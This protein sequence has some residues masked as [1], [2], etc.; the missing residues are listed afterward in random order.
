ML[1]GSSAS[2]ETKS[3]GYSVPS[4]RMADSRTPGRPSLGPRREDA[5]IPLREAD[6]VDREH[7]PDLRRCH[8][9]VRRAQLVHLAG[10]PVA[11]QRQ[12]RV[13]ARGQHQAQP[14][15]PGPY[16]AVQA[17]QDFGVSE[18]VRVID[19]HDELG[20]RLGHR[21]EQR[22]D[23]VDAG[24]PRHRDRRAALRAVAFPERGHEQAPEPPRLGVR[25]RRV[26][27]GH[28][29]AAA[30]D[31]VGEQHGLARPG[32]ADSRVS[33]ESA[34]LSSS[35]SRR[36]RETCRGGSCG[37]VKR[38][39]RTV[40]D[41]PGPLVPRTRQDASAKMTRLPTLNC[42]CL[43]RKCAIRPQPEIGATPNSI[44]R[45]LMWLVILP[46]RR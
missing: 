10:Q 13:A 2:S 25:R 32:P 46:F 18:H 43:R 44:Q 33:G 34:A 12:Q 30:P 11:V 14:R 28:P 24:P 21:A 35:A 6:A 1:P 41:K 29:G 9:Q 31:P 7:F 37:T 4:I 3:A 5:E 40:F 8:G 45:R 19:D 15:L 39:S 23:Q 27:P 16:Q 17:L 22:L 26:E 38:E 36:G 20:R 42:I